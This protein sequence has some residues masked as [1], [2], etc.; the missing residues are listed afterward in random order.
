MR[1]ASHASSSRGNAYLVEAGRTRLLLEAGLPVRELRRR[2]GGLADLTACL[3]T[4]EHADHA[5][6]AADLLRLGIDVWC[7]AGT[8]SALGLSGPRVHALR[9][10]EQVQIGEV[11]VLPFATTHDAAEPLGFVLHGGVEGDVLLFATDTATLP[12]ARGCGLTLLAVECNHSADLLG[13][14]PGAQRAR[15]EASHLS[16]ATLQRWIV[17]VGL[18]R[19]REIRLLHLSSAH[20]DAERFRTAIEA[21]TGIPT[22][23]EEE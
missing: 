19:C 13:E 5:R 22:W 8:A 18:T 4:H 2:V 17:D 16:L 20:S 7:S 6:G 9:D 23:V 14:M 11:A 1:F 3:I 15:L 12:P 21:Q 10:R